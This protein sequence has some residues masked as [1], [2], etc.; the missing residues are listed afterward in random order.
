VHRGLLKDMNHAKNL[1]ASAV[2][3]GDVARGSEKNSAS[4]SLLNREPL[5]R[6]VWLWWLAAIW[7]LAL[8]LRL[9]FVRFYAVP[10]DSD[11]FWNDAVGWNI[12]QGNGFTASPKAP[13]VPGIFRSPGYPLYLAVIYSLAGHSVYA[14]LYGQ[15]VLDASTAVLAAVLGSYF[16]APRVAAL[17]GLLYAIYPYAAY[18]CGC[19]G[20]D[21]L[22]TFAFVLSMV[23]MTRAA[24]ASWKPHLWIVVGLLL[25]FAGLIKPF[26]L[27]AAAI[28]AVLIWQAYA[29]GRE[30]FVAMSAL[31]AGLALM[32]VPWIVR[33]YKVFDRFVPVAVGGSGICLVMSLDELRGGAQFMMDKNI[34]SAGIQDAYKTMRDSAADGGPPSPLD[35][36][37]AAVYLAQLRDGQDL[38]EWE[39][40]Q[41]RKF[42]Q[43]V[44]P[45][46]P[47]FGLLLLRRMPRLWLSGNAIG[48]SRM[49]ALVSSS[50]SWLVLVPGL[51]GMWML[52]RSWK[53]LLPL[54]LVV[55]IV[56]AI[57]TPYAPET[58]YTLP[59]RPIMLLFVAVSLA[60][61]WQGLSSRARGLSPAR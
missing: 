35:D 24:R 42:A 55:L 10:V 58:R 56:T 8:A 6:A 4:S 22:L 34:N 15:A 25:G 60:T 40:G 1:S 61:L 44:K 18:Y 2:A 21:V 33:N 9:A 19:L 52:R 5:P 48:H 36:Q 47:Q 46:L 49:V 13:W 29:R 45:V 31:S 51:A 57:Y 54:Y 39:A 17:G 14:A 12:A 23:T 30:R 38:I 41:V 53:L 43:E 32:I 26:M 37:R 27:L 7:V 50:L 16:L 3:S 20:Q 28:S 59:A 11:L